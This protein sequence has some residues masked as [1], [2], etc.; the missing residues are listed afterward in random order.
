MVKPSKRDQSTKHSAQN[1]G[2]GHSS[3]STPRT[4]RSNAAVSQII[5]ASTASS[6][7]NL[8][9]PITMPT[10]PYSSAHSPLATSSP[11]TFGLSSLNRRL[12]P[13]KSS[14]ASGASLLCQDF[15]LKGVDQAHDA[16]K[17]QSNGDNTLDNRAIDS[18]D[19]S[20]NNTQNQTKSLP[21]QIDNCSLQS[22]SS[23]CMTPNSERNLIQ[24][25]VS[26]RVEPKVMFQNVNNL[27]YNKPTTRDL[28]EDLRSLIFDE[29]N[30]E[31][32]HNNNE[33][34]QPA[35]HTPCS[36]NNLRD[37]NLIDTN[38]YNSRNLAKEN[39][40]TFPENV[41]NNEP[42]FFI[43]KQFS[44]AFQAPVPTSGDVCPSKSTSTTIVMNPNN[45]G[46]SNTSYINVSF[47]GGVSQD[48][49]A[50]QPIP[51]TSKHVNSNLKSPE[52]RQSS[53]SGRRARRLAND[54]RFATI[55]KLPSISS[56][57]GN[58]QQ[59]LQ[60]LNVDLPP[61]W[62]ARLDAHNR[63]FYIDHERRT[64]TWQRPPSTVNL[65]NSIMR[66]KVPQARIT[67]IEV[68]G[69]T[70]SADFPNQTNGVNVSSSSARADESTEQQRALLNRR[71]TLRRTISTRR[72]SRNTSDDQMSDLNSS[73]EA[74]LI[75]PVALKVTSS[76]T[77]AAILNHDSIDGNCMSGPSTTRARSYNLCVDQNL[78]QT[79]SEGPWPS[80]SQQ[81]NQTLITEAPCINQ[82]S[83]NSQLTDRAQASQVS[84]AK[85]QLSPSISC[86]SALK[87][88]TRS[89]FF[90]LLHLN[91]EAL[92]HY[93][94]ST[95]LKYII[96]RVRK[97]KTNS[98]YERF[99]HNKDLV[100]FLNK[101]SDKQQPLPLGWEIKLDEHGKC[102]F[103]DHMRKATTY[104][105][106]RLPIELPLINPRRVPLHDH[107]TPSS[108]AAAAAA[109][110]AAA[111]SS[112]LSLAE[113]ASRSP[114]AS[115]SHL[116]G[117]SSRPSNV[118]PTPSTS[119]SNTGIRIAMSDLV[120]SQDPA[121]ITNST[122][123]PSTS[124]SQTAMISYE[125][126]I[127]AFF[128]QS[129]IFDL[130][131]EKRSSSS[132]MNASLREKISQIRKGGVSV[133]K[134]YSHDVNLMMIISLFDAEIDS[135]STIPTASSRPV[136]IPQARSSVGRIIVPGKR[137]FEDKLR[138]FYK[139]LEQ[140]NFGQGPNKLKLGIRRDHILEDAFTKVMSVNSKKDLQRSRLYVSFAG[141]E[142]LDYGGPSREFFFL[143]SRELFN[144]YYGK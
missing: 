18:A 38:A 64:T 26:S 32:K 25:D 42:K 102:F 112:S 73:R 114:E 86:P 40:V 58:P 72:S 57:L 31:P 54:R 110:V 135:I 109:A 6:T 105:D 101:F 136:H 94:T 74:Q 29:R 69:T 120:I 4:L 92:M 118:G 129:N 99:Q 80:T 137:D 121:G 134:K 22:P 133:L 125:E 67:E 143:L 113:N 37:D 55:S 107:R 48:I 27:S 2:D 65:G 35:D 44:N 100:A 61:N 47:S 108:I 142:G 111:S 63:V 87:F 20:N 82:E 76:S 96:N 41:N 66:I 84:R 17:N 8:S 117:S 5:I 52:K 46:P 16:T 34:L 103:I 122:S 78:Q 28:V 7:S 77:A 36:N 13:L 128:K 130:I 90:N 49:E 89:D 9:S 19:R 144:P 141:E 104:V 91:D 106:P 126:K 132:L 53:R 11:Q 139:K 75:D 127:V 140:K 45:S 131:K 24:S 51:S 124:S 39:D 30:E 56:T 33:G 116:N 70:I 23:A 10:L 93:N 3:I 59:Q 62:E 12:D 85:H 138:S 123:E 98:A 68:G 50:K 71:Y 115:S 119:V 97:D 15:F 21:V 83:T 95:N 88:L 14:I 43:D 81:T 60:D 79:T 1:G